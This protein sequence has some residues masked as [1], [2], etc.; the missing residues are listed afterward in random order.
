MGTVW[1]TGV[2]NAVALPVGAR[3]RRGGRWLRCRRRPCRRGIRR[4]RRSCLGDRV[5]DA[6][7]ARRVPLLFGVGARGVQQLVGDAAGGDAGVG[8]VRVVAM[9][10]AVD[11]PFLATASATHSRR[12]EFRYSSALAPT[13]CSTWLATRRAVTPASAPA[14]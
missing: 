8:A 14:A 3:L 9:Y 6:Q 2:S 1:M 4:R 11:A 13:A 7:S 12:R 5:R 10:N